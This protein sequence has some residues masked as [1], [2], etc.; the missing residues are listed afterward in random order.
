MISLSCCTIIVGDMRSEDNQELEGW[1]G[2]HMDG[3]GGGVRCHRSKETKSL[4]QVECRG[5]DA[6]WTEAEE[7]G[8]VT[9]QA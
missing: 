7:V 8:P 2:V 4:H 1:Q 3:R 5:V 6:K 9:A